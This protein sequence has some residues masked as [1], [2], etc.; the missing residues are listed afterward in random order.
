MAAFLAVVL[1]RTTVPPIDGDLWWHL[2]AGE[3]VLNTGRVPS[4][5][6][7]SIAGEG[8]RWISQDW[9][10]NVA[11]ASVVAVG[12]SWGLS[13][14]SVLF[15]A[16]VVVAFALLWM[17]IARRH[18]ASGWTAR[19]LYL[20]GGLI[21]AG[22]VLGVRVQTVDLTMTALAVWLLWGYL[23]QRRPWQLAALPLVALLWANLHAGWPILFL[24]GGAIVVGELLDRAMHR[25]VDGSAPL[26]IRQLGALSLAL[27]VSVPALLI[28][29]NG[30]ALLAYPMATA[31]IAAHRDFVFEWSRPDLATFPGQAL[32]VF[33][34]LIVLPTFVFGWRQLRSADVLWLIG[35]SMLSLNAIRFILIIGPIGAALAAVVLAP[36]ISHL[37]VLA[38]PRHLAGLIERPARTPRLGTL[39]RV[40]AILVALCGVGTS[41][42][43]VSPQLQQAAVDGAMPTRATAWLASTDADARVFNVYAW[44]GYIGRELPGGLVYIDGRSDI[45]GDALIREYARAIGLET[46]PAPLLDRARTDAVVFWPESALANWLDEQPSW[47]RAYTDEQAVIWVR[48]DEE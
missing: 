34:G 2:R 24:L 6:T 46:D 42:I 8:M 25:N 26:T 13:V 28:N 17:A 48:S 14:L 35:L 5:D 19:I 36:A 18:A 31:T 21:V 11:M 16:L 15:G 37:R 23:A 33:L 29:P 12:G 3:T 30:P 41:L 20:T 47:T 44:G 32:V 39:N 45:Y 40:L 1:V 9:L 27:A 4:V 10:S 22:P 43:R 38:L 7:W